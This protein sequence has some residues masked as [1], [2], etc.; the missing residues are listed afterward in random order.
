VRVGALYGQGSAFAQTQQERPPDRAGGT[1]TQEQEATAK[2]QTPEG[3][4][5]PP[6]CQRTIRRVSNTSAF[7]GLSQ[8]I[9][10]LEQH[11]LAAAVLEALKPFQLGP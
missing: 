6:F 7:F 4:P 2:A 8:T 9:A 1:S 10:L 5:T 11:R 3:T